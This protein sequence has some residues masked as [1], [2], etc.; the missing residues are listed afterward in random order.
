[1]LPTPAT[2]LGS[3]SSRSK[4]IRVTESTVA[5]VTFFALLESKTCAVIDP[6]VYDDV[7]AMAD[8]YDVPFMVD[9]L[10][11]LMRSQVAGEGMYQLE[12]LRAAYDMRHLT[13]TRLGIACIA[14]ESRKLHPVKW[15]QYCVKDILGLALWYQITQAALKCGCDDLNMEMRPLHWV[16]IAE[17][18]EL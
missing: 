12:S 17:K 15:D 2:P 11:N 5:V 3:S 1:M 10:A 4:L 7:L 9:L 8:K 13:N 18:F 16:M 14:G 6:T